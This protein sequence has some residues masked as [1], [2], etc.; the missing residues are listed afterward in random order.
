MRAAPS[1]PRCFEPVEAP[2]IW[3]SAWRCDVHGEVLPLWCHD[4]SP[5]ALEALRRTAQVPVW[6]PWPLPAGWLVTGFAEAGD[7]RAGGRA[8]VVALSGPS[9]T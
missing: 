8:S 9:L 1:C 7:E 6:L 2:D 3:S 5:A 4:P